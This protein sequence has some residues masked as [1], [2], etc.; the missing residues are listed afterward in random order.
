M[1]SPLSQSKEQRHD[2]ARRRS[3]NQRLTLQDRADYK[4]MKSKMNQSQKNQLQITH[5]MDIVTSTK[6]IFKSE[7]ESI[8][9]LYKHQ[10]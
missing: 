1:N 2:P 8:Q 3:E 7:R 6:H 5:H 10:K 4:P 9:F